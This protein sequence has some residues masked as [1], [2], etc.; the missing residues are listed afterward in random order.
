MAS[1]DF[2]VSYYLG[3]AVAGESTSTSMEG[4]MARALEAVLNPSTGEDN[5]D[6]RRGGPSTFS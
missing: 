2:F 5:G 1:L 3:V 6:G 4:D